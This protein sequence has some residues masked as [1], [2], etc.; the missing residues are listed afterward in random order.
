MQSVRGL[1]FE[2]AACA[3]TSVSVGLSRSV[4]F[5]ANGPELGLPRRT[6][7]AWSGFAGRTSRDSCA[8]TIS[9]ARSRASSLV[10]ERAT[11]VLTVAELMLLVFCSG[12]W[13]RS[14][15]NGF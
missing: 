11:W 8:I 9:S 12:H 6:V 15:R 1:A 7:E 14:G 10:R 3:A 13:T 4:R 5:E 2:D